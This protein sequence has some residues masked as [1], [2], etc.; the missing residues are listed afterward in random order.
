MGRK[1]IHHWSLWHMTSVTP[2]LR[3]PAQPRGTTV[4]G[5]KWCCLVIKTRVRENGPAGTQTRSWHF[6][7]RVQQSKHYTTVLRDFAS[8]NLT[9][10]IIS[11]PS[12]TLFH[13]RL[14]TF[15]FC[16]SFPLQPFFFFFRTDYMIPQ[17]F[18][19]TSQHIRFYF[20]VFPFLHFLAVVSVR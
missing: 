17:T 19:V 12:P 15:L 11:F 18:T 9:L 7:S 14:K 20:L 5:T 13:S 2:D 4:A 6:E 8:R 10:I 3:L 16:K 1:W